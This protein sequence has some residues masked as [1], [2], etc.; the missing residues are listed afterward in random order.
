MSDPNNWL[1]RADEIVNRLNCA[2]HYG[3]GLND[4]VATQLRKAYEAGL[5]DGEAR[6]R[7]SCARIAGDLETYKRGFRDGSATSSAVGYYCVIAFKTD[8]KFYKTIDEAIAHSH[9][10]ITQIAGK[11]VETWNTK[12]VVKAV[13]VIEPAY[14]E[15]E[16]RDTDFK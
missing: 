6:Y 3:A 11:R 4:A 8:R 2:R 14:R 12:M 10:L 1:E 5:N 13:S 16:F 7:S 9:E 15:R